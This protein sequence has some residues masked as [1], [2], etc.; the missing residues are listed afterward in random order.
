MNCIRYVE[1]IV[2]LNPSGSKNIDPDYE[3]FNCLCKIRSH[4]TQP[5]SASVKNV[6]SDQSELG[7]C[8]TTNVGH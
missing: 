2:T 3:I 1:V 4:V 5:L 6:G 7:S 8:P